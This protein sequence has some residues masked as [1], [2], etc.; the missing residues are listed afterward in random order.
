MSS[1]ARVAIIPLQDLLGVGERG[2]MNVPGTNTGNWEWNL[3]GDRMDPGCFARLAELTIQ[4]N[5]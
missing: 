1:P 2:R 5:R 3:G 4:N